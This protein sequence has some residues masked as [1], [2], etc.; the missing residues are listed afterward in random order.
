VPC[1]VCGGTGFVYA[2]WFAGRPL[3][4]SETECPACEGTGRVPEV[5]EEI[6]G[7]EAFLEPPG[8][9]VR[10]EWVRAYREARRKG[11]SPEAASRAADAEVW[12]F[13]ELPF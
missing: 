5:L 4:W 13:E 7:P 6:A 9:E 11:L 3:L 2:E 8:T 1:E 12:G 10:A